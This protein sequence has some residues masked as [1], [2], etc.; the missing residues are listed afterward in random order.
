MESM[1][2]ADV[3]KMLGRPALTPEAPAPVPDDVRTRYEETI[4]ALKAEVER[5]Q[6][7]L[8]KANAVTTGTPSTDELTAFGIQPGKVG[9]PRKDT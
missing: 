1:T 4:A 8:D 2:T 9:R 6:S 5:L 7:E 3:R